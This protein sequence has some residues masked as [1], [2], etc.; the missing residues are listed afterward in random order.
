MPLGRRDPDLKNDWHLRIE[1]ISAC[2][3]ETDAC[4]CVAGVDPDECRAILM[5]GT[6]SEATIALRAFRRASNEALATRAMQ[7][8]L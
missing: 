2:Y 4:W 6:L 3:Y 7:E 1:S 8:A 5:T